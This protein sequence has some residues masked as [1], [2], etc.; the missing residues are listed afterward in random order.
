MNIITS[1]LLTALLIFLSPSTTHADN[2]S[3]E[4]TTTTIDKSDEL[5]DDNDRFTMKLQG[6]LRIRYD[7]AHQTLDKHK[8][9]GS[10]GAYGTLHNTRPVRFGI[11]GRAGSKAITYAV[12][13]DIGLNNAELVAAHASFRLS[14]KLF[15]QAGRF[16]QY[17]SR[18]RITSSSKQALI[19]RALTDRFFDAGYDW[20]ITLRHGIKNKKSRWE[21][22]LGIIYPEIYAYREQAQTS[23]QPERTKD[24]IK[25]ALLARIG[26]SNTTMQRYTEPD[27]KRGAL[28]FS[29]GAASIVDYRDS[30]VKQD[31]ND[32][33]PDPIALRTRLTLD[34]IIKYYGFSSTTGLFFAHQ[35]TDAIHKKVD[36]ENK[37]L[38]D[39]D[40]VTTSLIRD[41]SY[42]QFG[43]SY[44]GHWQASYLFKADQGLLN[45]VPHGPSVRYEYIEGVTSNNAV[46][47]LLYQ[48]VMLGYSF[49]PWNN[50]RIKAQVQANYSTTS[51]DND[52]TN[53]ITRNSEL[54]G[55]GQI[56]L[57]F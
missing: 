9:L 2:T 21:G 13:T 4:S 12:T 20:G 10:I 34:G 14:K 50:H 52:D 24:A 30:I 6:R 28:R 35:T 25:G 49:Y 42:T 39:A 48:N 19:H 16:K 38:D 41:F 36:L 8:S 18:Q 54:K 3:T 44:G 51:F 7:K 47:H 55:I 27:L 31:S 17:F 43:I 29:T 23:I 40:E 56:Q 22:A 37:P 26:W 5:Q 15:I 11:K 45:N 46:H 32:T 1:I 53:Q 33:R 57:V